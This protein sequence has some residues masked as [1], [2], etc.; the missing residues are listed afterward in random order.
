[1]IVGH[2]CL[3]QISGCPPSARPVLSRLWSHVIKMM[4]CWC[5]QWI[6]TV[7]QRYRASSICSHKFSNGLM[8]RQQ[9]KLILMYFNPVIQNNIISACHTKL[10]MRYFHFFLYSVFEVSCI[11]YMNTSAFELA[12][13]HV[14]QSL[15]RLPQWPC[16]ADYH[17]CPHC[18][19]RGA[20]DTD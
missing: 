7:S 6:R 20:G 13:F 16:R 18:S 2:I 4:A 5:P 11:L 17:Q 15:A 1:M 9:V 14:L 19:H 8:K 12:M 3:Q 10:L